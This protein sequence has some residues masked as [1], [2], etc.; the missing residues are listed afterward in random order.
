MTPAA[1]AKRLAWTLPAA[2]LVVVCGTWGFFKWIGYQLDRPPELTAEYTASEALLVMDDL[3]GS[4]LAELPAETVA[5]FTVRRW[6]TDPCASGW[7]NHITW[8]GFVSVSVDYEFDRAA[9]EAAEAQRAD[10]AEPVAAA[11]RGMGMDP[12]VEHLDDGRVTVSA[13]RDDGLEITYSSGWGLLVDTGC[14]VDDGRY[15]Y[16]PP[17]G[18][19][20]PSGD[21]ELHL[22]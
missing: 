21:H 10:Y 17:H 8:D 20:A 3:A 4:L 9:D 12:E 13:E 2:L 16:T 11:L 15:V 5:K 14:V 18:N 7:D 6:E 22:R 1:W 19:I